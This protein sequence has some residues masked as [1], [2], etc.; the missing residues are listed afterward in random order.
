MKKFL[1]VLLVIAVMFTFSFSAAFAGTVSADEAGMNAVTEQQEAMAEAVNGYVGK[2]VYTQDSKLYSPN[3]D[4]DVTKAAVDYAFEI[5][6]P[7]DVI[8]LSPS[9]S[10]FDEFSGYEERGRVFK[11]LV[12]E[13]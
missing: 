2:F 6:K 10:S 9:T 1:T 8:L 7:G 4:P 11:Q 3:N 13:K 5:A 12:L